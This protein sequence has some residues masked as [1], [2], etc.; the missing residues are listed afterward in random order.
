MR[1]ASLFVLF[2]L[3]VVG[4][5]SGSPPAAPPATTPVGGK[6]YLPSGSVLTGGRVVFKPK[7]KGNQEA[8]GEINTDGSFKLTSY[9]KDD[10]ALAGEYVVVI[11]KTSYKSGSAVEVRANIAAKYLNESTSDLVVT[12]SESQSDYP[13]RLK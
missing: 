7:I 5:G 4:C 6:V 13:I 3:S 8:I 9:N 11:D 10:G 1:C 12:V 2:A